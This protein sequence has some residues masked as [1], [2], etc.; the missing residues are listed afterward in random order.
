[1]TQK[2]EYERGHQDGVRAAVTWLHKRADEMNDPHARAVLNSA[3][4]NLGWD[5]SRAP[6]SLTGN[7][8]AALMASLVASTEHVYDDIDRDHDEAN[9]AIHEQ[10]MKAAL[11]AALSA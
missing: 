2:P 3:A 1:M 5:H 9:R 11:L 6:R 4:T 10:A 7:E 8:A